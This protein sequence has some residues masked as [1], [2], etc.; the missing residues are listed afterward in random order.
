[1]NI[2]GEYRFEAPVEQVWKA[3]LDPVVLASIMPGCE[4]LELVDG[5]YV[6]DLN[7][8]IGPVQGKFRGKVDLEDIEELTGYTIKVD[9]KGAQG[10]VKATARISLKADGDG[11]CM[12]YDSKAQVGGRVASVG[13]R[14]L[15]AS[16]KAI[17]KQSL[18][19]LGEV[20][21]SRAA[22]DAG[23]DTESAA[24]PP[25]QMSQA[26]FAAGVAREVTRSL[27][28]PPARLA[29]IVIVV[30]LVALLGYWILG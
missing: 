14:L 2:E 27:L 9:G 15:E 10:F 28:P 17:I 19:G 30:F 20:M 18:D 23:G 7:I 24:P 26:R 12:A 16:A 22:A 6:G 25:P 3:L 1:M 29:L 8:K 21:K 4:K 5:Q 11:T 13:Q